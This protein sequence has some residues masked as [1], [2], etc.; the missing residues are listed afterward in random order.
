MN[1]NQLIH[2]ERVKENSEQFGNKVINIADWLGVNPD[3]LMQVMYSESGLNHRR[4]N[5]AFPFKDGYA[6]GL[7]QFIPSTAKHLGTTTQAL[8]GMSNVEQLDYVYKYFKPYAGKIKSFIDLYFVTF[9]PIAVGKPSNWVF[10]TKNL[11]KEAIAKANP[12]FDLNKDEQLT[13]AEV[14]AAML[15]KVP[16]KYQEQFKK[17]I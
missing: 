13:V 9:L 11:S 1:W 17:K 7:I 12:Y 6:T 10:Q 14:E 2:I 5:T 3:W 16:K 15:K 4:Q 8:L